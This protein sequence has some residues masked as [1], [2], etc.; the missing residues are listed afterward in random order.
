MAEQGNKNPYK[1]AS[2]TIAHILQKHEHLGHTVNFKTR[3][4][5]KDKKSHYVGK[6]QWMI[7]E[8]TH[9]MKIAYLIQSA[10]TKYRENHRNKGFRHIQSDRKPFLVCEP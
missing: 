1:W 3:K 8:D 5:F 2:S 4:H 9:E 10:G 7:F 6:D